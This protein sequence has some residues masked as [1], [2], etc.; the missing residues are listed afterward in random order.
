MIKESVEKGLEYMYHEGELYA[1][2]LRDEYKSASVSF[3]TPDSL[4]QQL[5]FLPHKKGD[6]IQPHR[7]TV[8]K[9]EI[10]YTQEVLFIKKGKVK[11]DF[12]DRKHKYV[13][14]ETLSGGDVVLL[15][16]GGHGFEML[17]DTVMIETKQGPY[18]GL[19]DKER[20]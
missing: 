5:G 18:V 20:F 10:L 8:H 17:Q 4:S 6:I 2:I 11:I 13:C 7:H 9:R 12:Y 19:E 16:A 15:C 14:S 1:I 3:F